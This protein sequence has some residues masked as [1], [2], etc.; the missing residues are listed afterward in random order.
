MMV[1]KQLL[2]KASDAVLCMIRVPPLSFNLEKVGGQYMNDTSIV[3]AIWQHN[4][5]ILTT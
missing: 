2:I 3:V 5:N 1:A 4:K